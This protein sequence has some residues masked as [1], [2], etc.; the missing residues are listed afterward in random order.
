[1]LPCTLKVY[2]F[3]FVPRRRQEVLLGPKAHAKAGQ[4]SIGKGKDYH[5][6]DE[7]G[8]VFK[9][10]RQVVSGLN[11]AQHEERHEDHT[12]HQKNGHQFAVLPRLK[13]DSR[14]MSTLLYLSQTH[15]THI[16]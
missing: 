9:E 2:L 10:D 14:G 4:V 15:H 5:E 11:I 1:M 6:D 13:V 3:G 12:G 8:I 16:Q 7:P